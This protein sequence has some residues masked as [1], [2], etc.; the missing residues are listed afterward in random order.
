MLSEIVPFT[1]LFP[2]AKIHWRFLVKLFKGRK[3]NP[4]FN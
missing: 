2:D 4:Y 1:E 3:R